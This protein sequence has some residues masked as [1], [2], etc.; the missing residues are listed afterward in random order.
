VVVCP[1]IGIT[2]VVSLTLCGTVPPTLRVNCRSLRTPVKPLTRLLRS[3]AR[4]A[5]S[6]DRRPP[7]PGLTANR[8]GAEVWPSAQ[9]ATGMLSS[10]PDP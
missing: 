1:R 9:Y 6:G 10:D 2:S 5:P 7:L 4:C 8:S 3:Q